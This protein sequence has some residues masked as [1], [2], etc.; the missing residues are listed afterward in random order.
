MYIYIY[1]Y[2]YIYPYIY[3]YVYMYIN[4][5][6]YACMYLFHYKP[7]FMRNIVKLENKNYSYSGFTTNTAKRY[8]VVRLLLTFIFLIF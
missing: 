8:K 7:N 6:I 4:I 3:I 1:I 2:I 5:N